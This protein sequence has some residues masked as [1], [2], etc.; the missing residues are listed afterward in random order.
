MTPGDPDYVLVVVG[1]GLRAVP[2]APHPIPDGQ[3]RGVSLH[4]CRHVSRVN[5]ET[6][7]CLIKKTSLPL[8]LSKSCLTF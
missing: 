8:P 5:H 1:D 2:Y 6:I 3:P 7:Y 4:P